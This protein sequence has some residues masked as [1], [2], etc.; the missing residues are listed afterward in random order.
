MVT[1]NT[2][3]TAHPSKSVASARAFIATWHPPS[4]PEYHFVQAGGELMLSRHRLNMPNATIRTTTSFIDASADEY[5]GP[6][7]RANHAKKSDAL[8]L[9][10]SIIESMTSPPRLLRICGC[11]II[12]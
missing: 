12:S 2:H 4:H 11:F 8:V 6:C 3:A 10:S 5:D 9:E 1:T 7:Y